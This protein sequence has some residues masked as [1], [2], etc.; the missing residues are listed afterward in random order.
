MTRNLYATLATRGIIEQNKARIDELESEL[1]TQSQ[2][3]ADL[4]RIEFTI[5]EFTMARI[6]AMTDKVN[7]MFGM[8]K[9]NLFKEQLNGG[10]AECC[11]A[12]VN[13]V[14]YPDINSAHKILAGLDI[15]STI[16]RHKDV[17]APCVVDNAETINQLP[18]IGSQMIALR[19]S[20]DNTLTIS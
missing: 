6:N 11:E 5:Q 16:C 17:C 9:F 3:L 7:G 10:V 2:A 12:T 19:V 1:K 14:P 4:E 18:D 15:I 20:E 8:V 13:G